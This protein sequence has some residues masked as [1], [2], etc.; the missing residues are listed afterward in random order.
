M[1]ELVQEI[2][3]LK[4][5][6][7]AVVLAHYY[8]ND[9]VQAIA[10]Y[11]GDSYYLAKVAVG[12]EESTIVFAGVKFMGE[13]AKILNPEK[14]VLMP[15]ANADCPMA[16]MAE[17]ERIEEVRKEYDDVAV[18][19]Y[20]NSTAELKMHSDVCVTSANAMKIVKALPN[21]NI[22][23]IPDEN[24][25]RYIAEKVPEKN[26]IFND[27]F[28]HVHKAVT[29]DMVSRAKESHPE[30]EVLIHPECTLDV[31]ELADYIGSTSG[32]IDYATKSDKKEFI[33]S[34]ELGVLYQLK[35]NNP[36]KTFFSAGGVQICPN[37]KK[38][39]LEKV[40]DCLRDNTGVVEVSDE[41]REKS[42]KPLAR[43][44]ELAK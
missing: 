26:F 1:N 20:I 16:H 25:G 34:T 33:I 27:G 24:L 37:M 8:V 11:I 44:L 31:L 41:K 14:T 18:V 2:E 22:F 15:D 30:A 32:I 36:D 23:F 7:N 29:A 10:D 38:V 9:E 6:K 40:R 12:L 35:K 39:T 4:K 3:K 21:K 17:I 28:C 13:S 43:M 42:L 5:E 19:C